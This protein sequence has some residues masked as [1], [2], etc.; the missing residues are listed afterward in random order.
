MNRTLVT[1]LLQA[2]KKCTPINII[3]VYVHNHVCMHAA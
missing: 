1:D 2:E 3:Y